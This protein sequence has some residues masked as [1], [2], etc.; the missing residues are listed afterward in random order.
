MNMRYYWIFVLTF[1]L[2]VVLFSS[3][4]AS[5]RICPGPP[6]FSHGGLVASLRTQGAT[7]KVAKAVTTNWMQRRP[8]T[9]AHDNHNRGWRCAVIQR[10]TPPP[11][12][13][14]QGPLTVP[15]PPS[16]PQTTPVTV[17]DAVD[18]LKDLV[19]VPPGLPLPIRVPPMPN[20]M[21]AAQAQI[22]L[23]TIGCRRAKSIVLFK[24]R[25]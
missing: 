2:S 9:V 5:A 21:G 11:T 12:K 16:V 22:P 4:H 25:D 20:V 23:N 17:P 3:A 14:G 1:L 24:W 19:P 18:V 15:Q 10:A 8:S 13:P 7:C 6:F